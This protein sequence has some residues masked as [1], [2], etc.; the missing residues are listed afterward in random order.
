MIPLALPD[1]PALPRYRPLTGPEQAKVAPWRGLEGR[2]LRLAAPLGGLPPLFERRLARS[3]RA[4]LDN[5]A[6]PS[7][8]LELAERYF[9]AS[10]LLRVPPGRLEWQLLDVVSDGR[11]A[12]RLAQRFLDAGD[13]SGAG[14]PLPSSVVHLEMAA[15]C[16]P[17]RPLPESEIYRY[18]LRRAAAGQ[19]ERRNGVALASPGLIDAY[20][21]H[22]AALRDRLRQE[23]Y[24]P[25]AA[26]APEAGHRLRGAGAARREAEVG[27]AI[28][29][30]GE[31]LRLLGGRHRTALAQLL[32]LPAMPVRVRLVHAHWLAAQMRRT[33]L[34]PH[35]ALP[36]GLAQL[37]EA[38]AAPSG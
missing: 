29:P 34:P 31:V 14:E 22:Y 4:L 12:F 30:G 26:L 18:M 37:A 23:G 13:W 24:R 27:V 15:L 35:R 17:A 11:R 5:P 7:P 2:L 16:D 19:P 28:G 21:A 10:L 1:G 9:G 25:R 20:F 36:A 38:L 32:G 33:G 6:A 3:L 8:S